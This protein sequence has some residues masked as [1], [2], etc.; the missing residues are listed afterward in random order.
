M[1]DSDELHRTHADQLCATS[2]LMASILTELRTMAAAFTAEGWHAHEPR[3]VMFAVIVN[4]AQQ[5]AQSVPMVMLST[6]LRYFERTVGSMPPALELLSRFLTNPEIVGTEVPPQ[7]RAAI[8]QVMAESGQGL[9]G[10]WEVY[11]V[12]VTG[13]GFSVP[14][15]EPDAE[16]IARRAVE[17]PNYTHPA[18]S[19]TWYSKLVSVSDARSWGIVH[20]EGEPMVYSTVGPDEPMQDEGGNFSIYDALLR[21][22]TALTA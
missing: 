20:R 11:G 17:D 15:E 21:F 19:Q 3:S 2:P 16:G 1:P 4:R 5:R 6:L 14:A 9:T 7:V 22:A 12:G 10:G 8:A 13:E 18:I